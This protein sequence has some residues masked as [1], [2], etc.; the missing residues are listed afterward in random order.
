MN[1]RF[2]III[3]PAITF[4][5]IFSFLF[6]RSADDAL[7]VCEDKILNSEQCHGYLNDKYKAMPAASYFLE[8]SDYEGFGMEVENFQVKKSYSI[9]NRK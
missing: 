6:L 4:L 8:I 5:I 7:L 2:L 1:A 9:T 3:I